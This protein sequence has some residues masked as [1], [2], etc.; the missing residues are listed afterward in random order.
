LLNTRVADAA[1]DPENAAARA[2]SNGESRA[3]SASVEP[4]LVSR[5]ANNPRFSSIIERFAGRLSERLD[6]MAEARSQR[7]FDEI[8]SLAHWLKGAGGT[9]GFDEFTEPA[10]QL[11]QFA[12]AKN[13]HQIEE[14]IVEL[15]RLADRIVVSGDGDA[16][17]AELIAN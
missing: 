3:K 5:L 1:A 10:A 15:R 6:A 12:K 4:P 8:A 9:V 2:K 11:E 13:A 17:Q 7:N 14:T 16:R